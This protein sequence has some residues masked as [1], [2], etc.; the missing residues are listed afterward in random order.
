M[1][2]SSFLQL[3]KLQ[4]DALPKFNVDASGDDVKMYSSGNFK[5]KKDVSIKTGV[6]SYI[7]IGV[8]FSD[9]DTYNT[10]FYQQYS[11]EVVVLEGKI[12][13]EAKSRTDGDSKLTSDL[14]SE[15]TARTNADTLFQT[16]LSGEIATR[17]TNDTKQGNDL[18]FEVT[19]ATIQ[20]GVLLGLV[21]AEAKTRGDADVALG[22]RI[23]GEAKTRG[24]NDS[25]E[26]KTRGDADVALGLRIDEETKTRGDNDSS[27]A[28]TRGD[29][30]VAL[31]LRI[32]N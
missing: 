26:A 16:A 31:G 28:K 21:N 7:N 30:D 12:S 1:S 23:D 18:A 22:L 11:D 29:A 4:T 25:S 20:E 10:D 32:T 14:S 17:V 8:K 9:L 2:K 13:T 5:F 3:F 27:E 24:D 6:A 19:R 15:V